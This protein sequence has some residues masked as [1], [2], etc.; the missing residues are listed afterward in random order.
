LGRCNICGQ[1]SQF[2]YNEEFLYRESLT[3]AECLTTSR[4]RSIARGVLRAIRE[5]TGIE[6]KSLAELDL[7]A[8]G[9]SLKVYD[10]QQ[11]FY[12]G[13]CAYPMPDLLSRCNWIEV[14]T[15][16]YRPQSRFG[17]RLGKNFT[18]QNLEQLTFADNTFDIVITSDVMEHVR[19]DKLAH[20]EI[21][22]VLK[23]GGIYL[24]TVPHFRDSKETL[25]R[26]AVIDPANPAGDQFLMEPEYHGDS[27]SQSG[28]ALSYRAYGTEL[29]G[30]LRSLG[31][32]VDY[33]RS[34][35]PEIGVM[36]TELFYCRLSK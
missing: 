4:Y 31:F 27:N 30:Y 1:D 33:C 9:V 19:L 15:S 23:P 11:P 10:T 28:R 22:R 32:D 29:D 24:F 12:Y 36:N 6:A 2:F 7:V 3:C 18:N 14:Q 5:L 26:V 35:F 34:D 8:D 16:T 20:Q 25:H 13:N 17:L 21:R